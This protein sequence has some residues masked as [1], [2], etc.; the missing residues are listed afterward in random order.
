MMSK[1]KCLA[2][3]MVVLVA[4]MLSWT[5]AGYAQ[6]QGSGPGGPNNPAYQ[7]GQG[8]G[9]P[10]CPNHPGYRQQRQRQRRTRQTPGAGSGQGFPGAGGNN[11]LSQGTS[12]GNVKN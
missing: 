9:N 5:E 1:K 3:L 4:G 11:P 2:G 8:Q 6:P 7:Q 12:P 10:A